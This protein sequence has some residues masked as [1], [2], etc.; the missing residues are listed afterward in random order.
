M[1]SPTGAHAIARAAHRSGI[2]LWEGSVMDKYA[3]DREGVEDI[4]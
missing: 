1:T 3:D 2:R 4:A